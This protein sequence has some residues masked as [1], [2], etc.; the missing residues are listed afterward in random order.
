[1]ANTVALILTILVLPVVTPTK[2]PGYVGTTPVP[3]PHPP[4]YKYSYSVGSAPTPTSDGSSQGHHE[5]RDGIN[6]Q[7]NYFVHFGAGEADSDVR[8]I[9]DDWGYHPIVRCV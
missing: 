4:H 1:M 2:P 5:S 8:Y 6:T 7:G 3:D 9:A